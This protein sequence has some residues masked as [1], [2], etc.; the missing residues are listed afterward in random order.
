MPQ[1]PAADK[2]AE[3]VR[4]A[5]VPVGVTAGGLGAFWLLLVKDDVGQ[6]VASAIIGLGLSYG[7]AMLKPFH[8]ANRRRADY[9][10]K[11]I[12]QIT[13]GVI[14]AA[15]GFEEKYLRCQA[16]DCES[17]RA[18]GLAQREGIFEPLLKDVF[19]ELQIDSAARL[20][21]LSAKALRQLEMEGVC[22]QSIWDFLVDSRREKAFRQLAILAWGGYGKT[23]LLKHVAYRYGVGDVPSGAPKLVP[24][25]IVLRKYRDVF[26]SGVSPDLPEFIVQHHIPDLPEAYQLQPVP[27]NWVNSLLRK[28]R[29]LVMFDGFDEM[30][31]AER[32]AVAKWINEQMRAYRQSVFVVTSRPKAYK[33]QD[34]A[35]RLV[36]NTPMWVQPFDDEQRRKFV[37]SW[38]LAQEKLKSRRDTPEVKKVATAGARDLLQQIEA[39]SELK[40][41]AKNPLLLNMISTFHRLYPGAALP[42]RRVDL[43]GEI[44]ELQLKAR[45]RDRRLDT[46]LLELEPQLVLGKVAVRMMQQVLKRVEHDLLLRE[47]TLALAEHGEAVD[48]EAFLKDVVQIS[49][50]IVQQEDEY[51]FAHLSFQEYLAAAYIAADPSEREVPILYSCLTHDWWKSTILLYAGKT[52]KPSRL[53]REAMR[54]GNH[55]LAYACLQQT[56]KRVDDELRA[57]LENLSEQLQDARYADLER[58]LQNGQWKEADEETYRLMITEVSKEFGQL[59]DPEDLL[60]FPCE[61]LKVIDGLWVKHSGGKFGFSVQKELYLECGGVLDGKYHKE[62]YLELY[63]LCGWDRR[64]EEAPLR[65]GFPKMAPLREGGRLL[66]W[67]PPI[68]SLLS[69]PDL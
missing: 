49:E 53:I 45:P 39:E 29:A 14:A 48:A 21:G 23:T 7:A 11:R 67:V 65:G 4:K 25:L 62:A 59:L 26:A 18:E 58:Y 24:V 61:P 37:E 16:S 55:D 43:Y 64:E 50:L 20:P 54:Q 52:K 66:L 30:P 60:N 8:D 41:L 46:V 17:V 28:G 44:C 32:P 6:A 12:D 2:S 9:A 34:F 40:D 31:R 10:G 35:D 68:F 63:K 27:P 13:E 57:E 19:V 3:F 42:K 36:L 22:K 47:V 56:T 51:E 1:P 38:Y 33:E 69:H 5:I 15:T